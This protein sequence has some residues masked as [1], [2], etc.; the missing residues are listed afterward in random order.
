M[1]LGGPTGPEIEHLEP[2]QVGTDTD[3][4]LVAVGI[5]TS[6]G[7][8]LDQ[9]LWCWGRNDFGQIGDD[10]RTKRDAPVKIAGIWLAVSLGRSH[11]CAIG[12]DE[13]RPAE[14]SDPW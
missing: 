1:V 7:I 3:W 5:E 11:T 13:I 14:R 2:A 6:C 8:K 10:T 4:D 9:S 12:A